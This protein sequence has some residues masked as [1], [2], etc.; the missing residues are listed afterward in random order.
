MRIN[1]TEDDDKEITLQLPGEALLY[2]LCWFHEIPVERTRLD[3]DSVEAGNVWYCPSFHVVVPKFLDVWVEVADG[4][5]EDVLRPCRE[6]YRN[7]LG[8]RLVI[9]YR[10]ELDALRDARR[11]AQ[12]IAR[13]R[14]LADRRLSSHG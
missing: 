14:L 3:R 9:L 13:L 7:R 6:E 10:E 5:C 11:P 8:R 1:V 12:F 4:E 2:G